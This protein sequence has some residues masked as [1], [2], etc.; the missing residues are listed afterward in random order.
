MTLTNSTVSGNSAQSDCGGIYNIYSTLT[1]TNSTVSGNSA[2]A[3]GGVCNRGTLTLT[4]STVSGN[5]AG[6]GDGGGIRNVSSYGTGS[7]TLTHSLI[8][9]NAA[10]SG[11][12]IAAINIFGPIIP[13]ITD[14]SLFGHSG[15][16]NTQAFVKFT[17]GVTDITATS[18]GTK[19]TALAAILNPTLANNGGPTATHNLVSGSPAIDAA[20]A[21]A[22][23]PAT[24][25][26][27]VSR[28][29]GLKCDLGAV[30]FSAA[31]SFAFTGFLPPLGTLGSFNLVK[32]GQSVPLQFSLDGDQGLNILAEGTPTSRTIACDPEA[33]GVEVEATFPKK[34]GSSVLYDPTTRTYT[35]LWR[36]GHKWAN[37]CRQL[38]VKLRD[39]TKHRA[40]FWFKK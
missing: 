19:P 17:P 4:N 18:D 30:E 15:L 24:D 5:S 16:S 34:G 14:L 32:A 38:I 13:P 8:S 23:C 3:S 12:E 29:V 26:R 2:G 28:P 21:D 39:G 40:N 22:N 37:T 6:Y 9:G 25:Q 35:Y 31:P 20:P 27:G 11:A 10:P 36:T 1:L 7:L 33:P